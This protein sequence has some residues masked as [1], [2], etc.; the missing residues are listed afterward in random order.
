MLIG[1]VV[2]GWA[3]VCPWVIEQAAAT[4]A[5]SWNFHIAGGIALVMVA[6]ALMLGSVLADYGLLTV[7]V[8][9]IISPWVLGL[10]ELVTKQVILYGVLLAATA[11]FA[12]P[13]HKPQAATKA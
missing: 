5:S 8:W 4:T 13:L 10:P 3:F 1:L 9:L 7:A 6:V 11:W 12:R 2:S